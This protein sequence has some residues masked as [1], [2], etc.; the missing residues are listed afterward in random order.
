M[1]RNPQG[2]T[3]ACS[4]VLY[5]PSCAKKLIPV[6]PFIRKGFTLSIFD[7]DQIKLLTPE[8]KTLLSG[9]EIDGL[10]HFECE[11]IDPST[12]TRDH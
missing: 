1:I 11:T 7:T 5:M 12:L 2:Q 8:G 9:K 6:T 4:K 10:Y 3:I